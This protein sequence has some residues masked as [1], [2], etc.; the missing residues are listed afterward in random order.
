MGK[1]EQLLLCADEFVDVYVCMLSIQWKFAEIAWRICLCELF[2]PSLSL[3][4][5]LKRPSFT[6]KASHQHTA[7]LSKKDRENICS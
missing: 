2:V 6:A 3:V 1:S 5:V 7:S 4:S